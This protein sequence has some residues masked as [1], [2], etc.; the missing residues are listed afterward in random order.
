MQGLGAAVRVFES[1]GC[2]ADYWISGGYR[3]IKAPIF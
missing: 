3:R 1:V 2:G